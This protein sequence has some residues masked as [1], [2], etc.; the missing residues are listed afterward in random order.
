M[1]PEA[2]R[3]VALRLTHSWKL[4]KRHPACSPP[5]SFAISLCLAGDCKR[6]LAHLAAGGRL[7]ENS[8]AYETFCHYGLIQPIAA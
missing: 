3:N 2:A 5:M 1:T 7:A 6:L 8:P 4:V